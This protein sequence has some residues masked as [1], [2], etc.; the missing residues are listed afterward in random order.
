MYSDD[1]Y[2]E[3]TLLELK[4]FAITSKV[5]GTNHAYDRVYCHNLNNKIEWN[6]SEDLKSSGFGL[7]FL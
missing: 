6:N 5:V 7:P 2:V 1:G 3:N 4:R